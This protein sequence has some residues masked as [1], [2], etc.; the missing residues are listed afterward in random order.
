MV[1]AIEYI[2]KN[3]YMWDTKTGR[4]WR[5]PELKEKEN[6]RERGKKMADVKDKKRKGGNSDQAPW[7]CGKSTNFKNLPA[8]LSELTFAMW[9]REIT[10]EQWGDLRFQ[11]LAL[12]TL[13]KAAEAYVVNLFEDANLCNPCQK[14][15]P[16]AKKC[17][18][19]M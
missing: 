6:M 3:R 18:V 15:H 1:P 5:V 8:S 2:N 19:G 9:V 17:S 13:Q 10:Q 4:W 12:L 11:A 16:H 14:C 7:P